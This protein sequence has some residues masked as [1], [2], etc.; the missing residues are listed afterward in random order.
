MRFS[1]ENE[2][3]PIMIILPSFMV[4]LV[5]LQYISYLSGIF[6]GIADA[7][8]TLVTG[9]KSY[10]RTVT[11]EPSQE[12]QELQECFEEDPIP[13]PVPPPQPPKCTTKRSWDISRDVPHCLGSFHF[14]P[15]L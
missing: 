15:C 5:K 7:E 1:R 6:S 10:S 3:N 11:V 14:F 12:S 13:P 9:D 8:P 4:F 2:I